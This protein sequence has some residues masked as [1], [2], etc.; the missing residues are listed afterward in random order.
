[1]KALKQMFHTKFTALLSV[2]TLQL[3]KKLQNDTKLQELVAGLAK[4][5]IA[6]CVIKDYPFTTMTSSAASVLQIQLR[7]L[8]H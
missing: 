5:E 3:K 8:T 7:L 4:L 2:E 6:K 1:M